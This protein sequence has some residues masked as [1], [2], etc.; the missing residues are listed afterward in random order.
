MS[1][2]ELT[3]SN[4][5][6]IT[7]G[8]APLTVVDLLNKAVERLGG[9]G[10]GAVVDAMEKLVALHERLEAREAEKAFNLA[11]IEFKKQCPP[12]PKNKSTKKVGGDS[13]ARF[14]FK[15]ADLETISKIVDP[16]LAAV[17]LSYTWDTADAGE[18]KLTG[19]C[20][21]SHVGGH[22]VES[23]FTAPIDTK[24][25]MNMT[26]QYG[27]ARTYVCRYAMIGVLGLTNCDDDTDGAVPQDPAQ[28][29]TIDDN[30]QATIRALLD[31]CGYKTDADRMKLVRWLNADYTAI[32]DIQRRD[33][34]R[35]VSALEKRRAGK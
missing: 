14:A 2:G 4:G 16:I 28:L 15:F 19:I 17:G 22:S 33:Y 32:A 26:Q 5:A 8:E 12:I 31:E 20:R 13:G 6:E 27:S 3:K 24:A 7:V 11:M 18:G 34:S 1:P 9:D 21:V 30:Q 25:S 10:A 23:R 35:A 29:E